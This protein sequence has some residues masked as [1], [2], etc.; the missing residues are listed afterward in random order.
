MGPRGV[1]SLEPCLQ[2][3]R[4]RAIQLKMPYTRETPMPDLF[5]K[6]TPP[7]LDDLEE[8][9]LALVRMQQERDAW[10]N[11]FQTLESSY[12]EDL[13]EKDDLIEILESRVIETMER[14]GDLFS[15]KPQAGDDCS[16]PASD[17]WK[18]VAIR[19]VEENQRLRAQISR[20]T[21]KHQ[22]TD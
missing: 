1:V 21:G 13:K 12:R 18:E 7:L 2:W 19:H 22:R 11:K 15:P 4:S 3:V 9:Q 8:L 5:V 10:K 17:D 20:L 16:V 14:Q 6:T